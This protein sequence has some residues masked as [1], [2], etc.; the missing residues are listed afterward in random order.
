MYSMRTEIAN[1]KHK[2]KHLRSRRLT[3]KKGMKRRS[4]TA[5]V[6]KSFRCTVS[7]CV[8]QITEF[9]RLNNLLIVQVELEEQLVSKDRDKVG[10]D[11]EI[12]ELQRRLRESENEPEAEKR[13]AESLEIDL[14]AER[15]KSES[16]EEASKVIQAALDVAQDNYDEVQATV[17][18]FVNNLEWLQQYGIVH[19]ANSVLNS[20]ELDR[21]VAALTIASRHVGHREGYAECAS[22][23]EAAIHV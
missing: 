12:A 3:L 23:V 6:R 9:E 4:R 2:L 5:N 20:I 18:P 17:E 19:A 14:E 16:A 21:V 8:K 7:V 10:K 22:H 13:K 1:L 11:V 15:I